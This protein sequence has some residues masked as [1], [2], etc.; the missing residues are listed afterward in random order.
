M[1]YIKKKCREVLL[2]AVI[3][4]LIL[5][6]FSWATLSE[7]AL[8]DKSHAESEPSQ[9]TEIK[10]NWNYTGGDAITCYYYALTNTSDYTLNETTGEQLGSGSDEIVRTKDD[11]AY[12]FYIAAYKQSSPPPPAPNEMGPVTKYGPMIIDTRAPEI[13]TVIG[14]D[15]NTTENNAI[16]LDISVSDS[17]NEN[18]MISEINISE[19]APG[20]GTWEE[21]I[22]SD[23]INCSYDLKQGEGQYTLRIQVKDLAG[24]IGDAEPYPITYTTADDVIIAQYTSVPTLSQWSLLFFLMMLICIGIVATRRNVLPVKF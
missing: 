3:M 4:Q 7:V 20:N 5:V 22:P 23:R 8:T 17:N 6:S 1:K 15:N 24:N 2:I 21:F 19:G 12:Y 9:L 13:V 16:N 18:E 14:P 11:G 10:L